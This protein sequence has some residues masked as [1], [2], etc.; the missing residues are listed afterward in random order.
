MIIDKLTNAERY[1]KLGARIEQGFRFLQTQ[2][3][4][5]LPLGRNDIDGDNLFALVAEYETRAADQCLLEAHR[6]YLDIQYIVTGQE[7]MGY[8][9]LDGLTLATQYDAN[10]DIA[11]YSGAEDYVTVKSGMFTLFMPDDAH[12]PNL[13]VAAANE[14]VKKIVIKVLI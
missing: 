7:K 8:A 9:S 2:S 6:R 13:S 4:A 10:K 5:D 12:K 11:F 3:L 1:F 14:R